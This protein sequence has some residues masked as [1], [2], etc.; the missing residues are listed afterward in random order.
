MPKP[1]RARRPV[2]RRPPAVA[3]DGVGRVPE[4]VP[5]PDGQRIRAGGRRVG[6][7]PVSERKMSDGA[8]SEQVVRQNCLPLMELG[9]LHAIVFCRPVRQ[10]S[11]TGSRWPRAGSLPAIRAGLARRPRQAVADVPAAG[12]RRVRCTPLGHAESPGADHVEGFGSFQHLHPPPSPGRRDGGGRTA[13]PLRPR[14]RCVVACTR[15]AFSTSV[16]GDMLHL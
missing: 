4:V 15:D 5:G 13:G 8:S 14:S 16:E 9:C 1:A 10:L 11:P 6:G 7:H 12:P 3:R 2:R